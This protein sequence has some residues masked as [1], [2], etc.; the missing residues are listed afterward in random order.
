MYMRATLE[1]EAS[2]PGLVRGSQRSR[3][4]PGGTR[5]LVAVLRIPR[6]LDAT[7]TQESRASGSTFTRHVKPLFDV[8]PRCGLPSI[9]RQN[10]ERGRD[11]LGFGRSGTAV[12]LY[13]TSVDARQSG[14]IRAGHDTKAHRAVRGN[15]SRGTH[16]GTN[17]R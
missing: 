10:F 5:K 4:H 3:K 9:N 2:A 15:S 17:S 13:R 7:M 6:H 12:L 14:A 11:A 16:N 8:L 1:R